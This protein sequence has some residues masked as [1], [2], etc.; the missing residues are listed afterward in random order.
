[1]SCIEDININNFELKVVDDADPVA[2]KASWNAFNTGGFKFKYQ[3]LVVSNDTVR[4]ERPKRMNQSTAI[5]VVPGIATFMYGFSSLISGEWLFSFIM[6]ILG[7]FLGK[8]GHKMYHGRNDNFKINT[9][10]GTYSIG[11]DFDRVGDENRFV[12]GRVRDIHAIQILKERVAY[13]SKASESK[14]QYSYEMNLVFEDGE[15]INIMDH[16]SGKDVDASAI[17][18]GEILDIPIWKAQY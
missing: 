11:N 1:M 10:N 6:M 12:E 5:F 9:R 4:I 17:K 16:G 2:R 18:L 15:R 14:K 7:A 13:S 8:I 3:K